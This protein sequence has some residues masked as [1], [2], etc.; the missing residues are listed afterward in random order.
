MGKHD[1]YVTPVEMFPNFGDLTQEQK[2]FIQEKQYRKQMIG[3]HVPL[4]QVTDD[5]IQK[6]I[7]ETK[8][9][10]PKKEEKKN[11]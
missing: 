5:L 11:V 7:K 4:N 10:K 9:K 6:Q 2:L 3:S 8:H 1:K